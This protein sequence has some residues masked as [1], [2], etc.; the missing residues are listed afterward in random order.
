MS[1]MSQV[2]SVVRNLNELRTNSPRAIEILRILLQYGF[3]DVVT[4]LFPGR[5]S[6]PDLSDDKA[7]LAVDRSMARAKRL[8]LAIEKLGPTFIKLGQILSTRTDIVPPDICDELQHLQDHVPPIAADEVTGL[9][10]RDLNATL[11]VLFASFEQAPL[12]CASIAQ[13]H[14]ARMHDRTLDD[15]TVIP[16]PEV[17]VK[18]QRPNLH[19]GIDTDLQILEFLARRS[20][21]MLPELALMDPAGIVGEFAKALRK[22]L[23]FTN[24]RGN[25]VRCAANFVDVPYLRIP[26]VY[27]SHCTSRILTMERLPGVKITLATEKLGI[28]PYQVAP[29]MLQVLF[30]MVFEDGYFHGDLH[31]GNI[32]ID[33]DGNIGLIDFGLVGRL[34]EVQR[35]H[36]LDILIGLSR[37]DYRLVSK[38]FFELGIKL[39]GVAYNYDVFEADVIEVIERHL[40]NKTLQQID[41]GA[42]FSDLVTGAIRHQVKMPPTYTMVFKALMTVEGIGK[43]LAP[44]INFIEHAQPFV[45]RVLIERYSPQRLL[46]AGI[47]VGDGISRMMRLLPS[48]T[49][50]LLT[51]AGAGRLTLRVRG[52]EWDE[53]L[54]PHTQAT[55]QVSRAVMCGCMVVAAAICLHAPRVAGSWNPPWI[56][57]WVLLSLGLLSWFGPGR[58]APR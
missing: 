44:E 30:K 10:E 15:G 45:E 40:E 33:R 29:R 20:E 1:G 46:R 27:E 19:R 14:V 7:R 25:M 57:G 39:P 37:Q 31:P 48:V 12:A 18:V 49:T 56:V 51:D 42:F 43:T 8:R 5:Q 41:I 35:D 2:V 26:R 53:A 58:R 13:V 9:V 6:D 50:Q 34:T 38:V 54:R 47:E 32:L 52:E 16:G 23:D 36:I 11:E 3:D 28:D 24:E 21:K 17:V 55:W 4:R 22:E